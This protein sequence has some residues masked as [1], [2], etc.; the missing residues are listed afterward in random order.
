MPKLSSGISPNCKIFQTDHLLLNHAEHVIT[1]E[2]LLNLNG[3]Y[4]SLVHSTLGTE[5]IIAFIRQW[6]NENNT[7][8]C[9]FGI[10]TKW[11]DETFDKQ[12][13]LE[14]FDA[15]PWDPEKRSQNF[16]YNSIMYYAIGS[17]SRDRP[18]LDCSNDADIERSDGLLA[19]IYFTPSQRAFHFF[20]WHNRFNNA[21]ANS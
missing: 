5:D 6:L 1:R 9:A 12:K 19:T 2:H 14:E 17:P 13:I 20:I 11:N 16:I 18:V 21:R 4:M 10:R 3:I 8:M 15:K 7:R